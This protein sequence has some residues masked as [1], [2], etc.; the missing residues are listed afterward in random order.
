VNRAGEGL[1]LMGAWFL[2]AGTV[3]SAVGVSSK[4]FLGDDFG[5]ELFAKGNAIEAFG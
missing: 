4:P 3:T 1:V 5:K 2:L